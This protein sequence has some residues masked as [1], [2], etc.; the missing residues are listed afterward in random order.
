[1]IIS[2]LPL[3]FLT[4]NVAWIVYPIAIVQGVGTAILLNTST[5]IISDVVGQDNTSS[6]FVYGFYSFM[7][8]LANGIIIS[9]LVAV[10]SEEE[11]PLRWIISMLPIISCSSALLCSWIATKLYSNRMAKISLGSKLVKKQNNIQKIDQEYL[12]DNDEAR[13][14]L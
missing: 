11:G 12:L 13:D 8:K 6:A 5:S 4:V 7:D 14:S 10:Y 3:Y 9:W 1:M 2:S